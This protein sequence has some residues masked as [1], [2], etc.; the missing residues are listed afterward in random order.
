LQAS[1]EGRSDDLF[2]TFRPLGRN[3]LDES[4]S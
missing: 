2:V 3:P 1:Q 4:M